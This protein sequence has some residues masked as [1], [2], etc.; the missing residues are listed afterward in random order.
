MDPV[1]AIN[2]GL[3][4]IDTVIG[5]INK[6]KG[7]AGLTGDQLAS[8]ADAQDLKNLEAIKALVNPQV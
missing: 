7:Q 6:I 1:M 3:L 2:L 8:M 5:E 4:V